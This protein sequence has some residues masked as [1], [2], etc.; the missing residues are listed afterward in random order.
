M[1]RTASTLEEL[2]ESFLRW[3]A[4]ERGRSR[5]TLEA[6]RRDLAAFH[7][8]AAQRTTW[9]DLRPRD[10]E[11]YLDHLRAARVAES[12][13]ARAFAAI[14]AFRRFLLAEG[15]CD[16]DPTLTVSGV[17]VPTGV[18]KPLTVSEMERLLA[19]VIGVDAAQRRDRALCEMLY[20]TGA[21][22]SEVCG[23]EIADLSMGSRT[24]RLLG[25]GNK[26]R[27]VP[28]GAVAAR[29]VEEYL[30]PGGRPLLA[31]HPSAPPRDRGALF[32][33]VRG[34]RLSRQKV[35]DIV[36]EAGRLA[37]ISTEVSPH[38]LRHSCATHMLEHGADIRVVQELLG[39][40][41]ISTTQVY[42]KVTKSHLVDTFR[43]TH[44][45]AGGP[46]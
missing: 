12:S 43:R 16:V 6:Y 9:Q 30:E 38:V 11:A 13:R 2:T 14:R 34:R 29:A 39:H 17:R 7:A 1:P 19:A 21:R 35:F 24:V 40:A 37:G 27:I 10:V 20:A 31:G 22:V 32:L 8:W 44:P 45:R 18:P 33:S 28:F 5:N 36:R 23:L 3:L 4:V 25:K 41:T 46:A 42:T 26:Q 15:H